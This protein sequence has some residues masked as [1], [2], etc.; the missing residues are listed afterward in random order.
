MNNLPPLLLRLIAGGIIT[1]S[2]FAQDPPE[3]P[4]LTS[5]ARSSSTIELNW[6]PRT[7][8]ATAFRFET[9]N[10]G[11]EEAFR[12]D[13]DQTSYAVAS[14]RTLD[15]GDPDPEPPP[16]QDT[17]NDGTPDLF[18]LWPDDP[19]RSSHVPLSD[20]SVCTLPPPET[21]ALN[22]GVGDGGLHFALDD[23]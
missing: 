2:V 10:K 7:A 9:W 1:A 18:D 15:E 22:S 23:D 13:G 5:I 4:T 21:F 17:D 12:V 3:A 11:W 6:E 20:H 8:G 14:D 19:R 16:D